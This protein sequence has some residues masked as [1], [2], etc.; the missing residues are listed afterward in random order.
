MDRYGRKVPKHAHGTANLKNRTSSSIEMIEMILELY[1]T[2]GKLLDR[3][4]TGVQKVSEYDI[5]F[6]NML[7]R[8]DG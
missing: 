1:D 4:E 8:A 6:V 2:E 3:L 5:D 7:Q